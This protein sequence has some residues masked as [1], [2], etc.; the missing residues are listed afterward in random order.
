MGAF[1][2][3]SVERILLR[4]SNVGR[5]KT[6]GARMSNYVETSATVVDELNA[7]T[8]DELSNSS[9]TSKSPAAEEF[10]GELDGHAAAYLSGGRRR[11]LPQP[12]PREVARQGLP[13]RAARRLARPR[14]QPLGHRRRRHPQRCASAGGPE[15]RCS[16][17]AA[18]SS[19]TT[20]PST[21]RSASSTSSTRS[22]APRTACTSASRPPVEPSPLAPQPGGPNGRS[23]EST[24]LLVGP[25]REWV[26]P[27]DPSGE[28]A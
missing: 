6:E 5:D 19:C 12:G 16:T 1:S 22:A 11:L 24:F 20:A 21:T 2:L 15:R 3:M 10:V 4:A 23:L 9:S 17:V 25:T 18:A 26:G 27:D 7:Q 8:R 28:V 13:D 14:L